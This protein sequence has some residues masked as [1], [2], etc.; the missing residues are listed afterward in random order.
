MIFSKSFIKLSL[1]NFFTLSNPFEANS[2]DKLLFSTNFFI[3]WNKSF[4]FCFLKY[5]TESWAI[6]LNIGISEQI[7]GTLSLRASIK[8]IP[9]PSSIEG[10]T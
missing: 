3:F 10:N 1:L 8:G 4:S 5:N 7:T 6:Y 9:K 2:F